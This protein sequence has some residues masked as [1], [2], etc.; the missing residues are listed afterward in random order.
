M[1]HRL[2]ALVGPSLGEPVRDGTG[3]SPGLSVCS[4]R[5]ERTPGARTV[6]RRFLGRPAGS[7]EPPATRGPL[8]AKPGTMGGVSGLAGYLETTDGKSLVVV[9]MTN[10]FVGSAARSRQLQDALVESLAEP[11]S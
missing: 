2:S 3:A 11:G 4:P 8:R 5:P 1:S 10:G 7:A 9:I 6:A